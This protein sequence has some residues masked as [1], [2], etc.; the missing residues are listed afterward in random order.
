MSEQLLTQ[1]EVAQADLDPQF[2]ALRNATGALKRAAK[3]AGEE[4]LD[5]L[6]M[7]KLLVKLEEA[8]SEVE[9]VSL[10]AATDAFAAETQQ[11]LDGL[12]FDFAK[13]LRDVFQARGLTVDGRP[14]T[15]SVGLLV[16]QIDIAARKAQWFYG[17]EPLTRPI[18]LS[19]NNLL[20][21]Y[22]AQHKAIEQRTLDAAAFMGELH[23]AWSELIE[24]RTQRPSGGRINL[25]ELFAQ[26]TMDRQVARF[27]NAPS[28][29]T[30][31]DYDRAH[32]VR[33]LVLAMEALPV[34]VDG[35]ELVFHLAGATK[36]QAESAARSIW[37]PTSALDGEYCASLF[38]D[39][40]S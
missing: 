28:R 35:S 9:S 19:I 2:K 29:G 15:L 23:K 12:A 16:L 20:K 8:A 10:Q 38:F 3:L 31:K 21:A 11:A 36:S 17:K 24:K 25:V 22:D 6:A 33:D 40:K 13:D 14:P 39:D 32:F 30:F 26:V 18:P 7:N 34:E 5:A 4:K 27:W 1:L 37:I